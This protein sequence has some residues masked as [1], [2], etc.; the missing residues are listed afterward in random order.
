[1]PR[2]PKFWNT[3]AAA[4][5]KG[6]NLT[7]GS[8]SALGT[9]ESAP[10]RALRVECR[11]HLGTRIPRQ[12]ASS[13]PPADA[14]PR[15]RPP[16]WEHPW[17]CCWRRPRL[18]RRSRLLREPRLKEFR[19][20]RKPRRPQPLLLRRQRPPWNHPQKKP[21]STPCRG[22]KSELHA[23]LCDGPPE[24]PGPPVPPR[25]WAR[26]APPWWGRKAAG[27]AGRA[28]A[29]P[30]AGPRSAH[31]RLPWEPKWTRRSRRK[32]LRDKDQARWTRSQPQSLRA[33]SGGP[34]SGN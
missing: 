27:A 11:S 7:S 18:L 4:P 26:S 20:R 25:W 5:R 33:P 12:F 19:R 23:R 29:G 13:T 34:S 1:M 24:P 9:S 3:L 17:S 2:T 28:P 10:S 16:N 31:L 21:P 32:H 22:L 15:P 8:F 30:G 14:S 6:P